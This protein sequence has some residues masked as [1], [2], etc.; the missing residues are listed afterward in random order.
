MNL[1]GYAGKTLQLHHTR[2]WFIYLTFPKVS[3]YWK[4][5][6]KLKQRFNT[7]KR[8]YVMITEYQT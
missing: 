5:L 6:H 1:G 4:Y 7:D 3:L 2:L 8:S